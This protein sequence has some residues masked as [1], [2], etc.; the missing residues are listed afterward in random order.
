L[1]KDKYTQAENQTGLLRLRSLF[2]E[3]IFYTDE[4]KQEELSYQFLIARM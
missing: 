1:I 4:M 2:E 3:L